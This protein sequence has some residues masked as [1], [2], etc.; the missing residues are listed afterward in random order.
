MRKSQNTVRLLAAII[1]LAAVGV[2]SAFGQFNSTGTTTV[3]VTVGAEA[4]VQIDTGTTGL[5]SSGTLF[6][7]YTGTTNYTYKIRTTK[8]GGTGTITLKVTSD[9]SPTGGPSVATPPTSGDA[10]AYTCT[11]VA[12]ASAC[13]AQTA[14]TTTSTAVASFG[15][16]ATSAKAGN[17][18][19]AVNWTLT[20]D[21]VYQTGSFNAVATFTISAT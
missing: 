18:G 1:L 21:P 7:D 10:L 17:S 4:S 16:N 2:P 8:T 13:S 19:N 6:S 9:F 5:T 11:V 12:P 15:A 14:S 3:S 20:N